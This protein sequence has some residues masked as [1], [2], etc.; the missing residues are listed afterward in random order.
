MKICREKLATGKFREKISGNF[1]DFPK[2]AVLGFYKKGVFWAA[3]VDFR[4]FWG[5]RKS[6]KFPEKTRENFPSLFP[7]FSKFPEFFF[8][9]D[10]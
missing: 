3:I 8:S 5:I 6:P 4:C 9:T 7:R 1:P 10:F 2:S